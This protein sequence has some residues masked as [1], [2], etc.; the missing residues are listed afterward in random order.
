[1]SKAKTNSKAKGKQD[2]RKKAGQAAKQPSK[3]KHTDTQTKAGAKATTKPAAKPAAKPDTTPVKRIIKVHP[4]KKESLDFDD[5]SLGDDDLSGF[6]DEVSLEDTPESEPESE[7]EQSQASANPIA[8]ANEQIGEVA[9][10]MRQRAKVEAARFLE[11]TDSEFWFAACFPSR[12]HKEE[13]LEYLG[14]K[15]DADKYVDGLLLAEVLGYNFKTPVPKI[16]RTRHDKTWDELA[17]DDFEA[18]ALDADL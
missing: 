11:V 7:A 3:T 14:L 13:L 18:D 17:M 4:L 12:E 16:Y 1:M 8:V 15:E 2:T 6:G 9:H 5:I 10:A